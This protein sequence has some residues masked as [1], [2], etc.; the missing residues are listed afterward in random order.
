[1][2]QSKPIALI[3]L[4]GTYLA[5]F[6]LIYLVMNPFIYAILW[7]G[8]FT[9]IFYPLY[10]KILNHTGQRETLSS[11]ITMFIIVFTVVIPGAF[12]ITLIVS[13]SIDFAQG[14]AAERLFNLAELFNNPYLQN[15]IK[16]TADMLNVQILD[17]KAVFSDKLKDISALIIN[18]AEQ[19]LFEIPST[20]GSFFVTLFTTF[21]MLKD[22]KAFGVLLRNLLPFSH[23]ET[24]Y[25][26]NNVKK[27]IYV[28]FIGVLLTA[29]AQGVIA[30]VSFYFIGIKSSL[31]LGLMVAI[32]SLVPMVGSA[33]VWVPLAIYLLATGLVLKGVLVIIVGVLFISVVDNF[34]RPI[35]L[36]QYLSLHLVLTFF[37]LFGGIKAFGFIGIFL[38]PV[39]ISAFIGCCLFYQDFRSKQKEEGADA[40]GQVL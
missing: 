14:L 20:F 18:K 3:L 24:E 21:F 15:A 17:L 29:F 4:W 30:F 26:F 9:V 11:I 2:S 1:M 23:G 25:Y 31:L 12:M 37:S 40:G 38:G 8:I 33:L 7:A 39:I 5:L 27:V 32:A 28:T 36:H 10:K 16:K 19:I 34:V 35:F 6:Y 22:G 13:E